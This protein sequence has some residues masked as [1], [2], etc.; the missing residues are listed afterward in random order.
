MHGA[1]GT[2]ET[3]RPICEALP[4]SFHGHLFTFQGHGGKHLYRPFSI[5]GFADEVAEYLNS[6]HTTK[7]LVFGYS[8]GGYVALKLAKKNPGLLRGI[9]TLGSKFDWNP[10][11]T[12]AETA[13]LNARVLE[14]KAPAFAEH[15]KQLHGKD[16]VALLEHSASLMKDLQAQASGFIEDLSQLDLPVWITRGEQDRMVSSEESLMLARHIKGARYVELSDSGHRLES[17]NQPELLKVF[18]EAQKV[19]S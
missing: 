16:W 12:A 10:A 11:F 8:M 5:E 1:L 14:E 7:A 13:K 6:Q 4:A 2:G 19:L 18:S 9:I 17:L 3:L 15:L